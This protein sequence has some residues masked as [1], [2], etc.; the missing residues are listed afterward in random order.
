M[1]EAA[2]GSAGEVT[3]FRS[4]WLTKEGVPVVHADT[5]DPDR[6]DVLLRFAGGVEVL[7]ACGAPAPGVVGSFDL[8]VPAAGRSEDVVF[9][10]LLKDNFS[11]ASAIFCARPG[12]P[13]VLLASTGD[14]AGDLAATVVVSYRD[15]V[16]TD[17]GKAAIAAWVV[18]GA[19]QPA[20]GVFTASSAGLERVVTTDA[21]VAAFAGTTITGF[22]FDLRDAIDVSP[23]GRALVHVGIT[24]DRQPG[25]KFGALL[26]RE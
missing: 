10:A 19:A 7:A 2:P 15:V 21:R 13:A 9:G 18:D 24:P 25:A 16:A 12:E 22:L 8:I 11:G 20:L 3:G 6:P 5:D 1:K 17:G 26:L 4:A 23:D 14:A